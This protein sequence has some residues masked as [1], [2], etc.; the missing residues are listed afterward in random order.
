MYGNDLIRENKLSDFER[1]WS[2]LIAKKEGIEIANSELDELI[3]IQNN[4][5]DRQ[6]W[7]KFNLHVFN[8]NK[9]SIRT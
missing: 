3:D 1:R 7:S 4:K 9:E 2:S 8:D 6:E 5:F